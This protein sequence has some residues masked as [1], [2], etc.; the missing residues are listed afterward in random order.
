MVS[1]ATCAELFISDGKYLTCKQKDGNYYTISKL[2]VMLIKTDEKEMEVQLI[3]G[4]IYK[5]SID[6]Y[7]FSFD[8][9]RNFSITE[10]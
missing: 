4:D 10:K 2:S 7:D 5:Y 8:S 6:K 3:N 9:E 1:S